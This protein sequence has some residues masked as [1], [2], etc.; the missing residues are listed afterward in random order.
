[1][2]IRQLLLGFSLLIC[3]AVSYAHITISSEFKNGSGSIGEIT[4]Y[5]P[6]YFDLAL[7]DDNFDETL[8]DSWRSWWYVK[9][10]DVKQNHQKITV[11]LSNRGWNYFTV[12]AYSYDNKTW[13]RVDEQQV[14]QSPEC[15]LGIENC[16]L[17]F[18]QKMRAHQV[19]L[20]SFVPYTFSHL[21]NYLEKIS[22]HPAVQIETLGFSQ[23]YRF[24]IHHITITDPLARKQKARVWIHARTHPAET[25]SSFILEGLINFLLSDQTLAKAMREQLIFHI[26]PMH[27]PDGVFAGNYRS[28]TESM[29]F[30]PLWFFDKNDPAQLTPD[31]PK[32]NRLLNSVMSELLTDDI[33]IKIAL[34]LHASNSEPD[35]AIFSFPHFGSDETL[36]TPEQINLWND[37]LTFIDYLTRFYENRVELP[38][39]DGGSGFLNSY[40]PETWWWY[41]SQDKVMAITLEATYGKAGYDH[42]ITDIEQR[43]FGIALAKS[44]ATYL[45]LDAAPKLPEKDVHRTRRDSIIYSPGFEQ[46][47]KD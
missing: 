24:P 15:E 23:A 38:P 25:P 34:N 13:H 40:Y 2:Q 35:T 36:Y 22:L 1:M 27:N 29:N 32:E 10:Y 33:P 21:E 20:A 12:P 8:P 46:L 43:D 4:Q 6:T 19:Y 42:W 37:Q 7:R 39:E 11:D 5:K 28:N 31:A 16:I 3:A 44:I 9:A 30:E 41:N 47:T 45:L 17:S 14:S 18:E 26:V